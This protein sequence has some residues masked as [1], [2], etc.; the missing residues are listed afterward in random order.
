MINS[1]S[2]QLDQLFSALDEE[3]RQHLNKN[4]IIEAMKDN[5]SNEN[6]EIE[7]CGV[8]LLIKERLGEDGIKKINE[9]ISQ[10][11]KN[12]DVYTLVL[13]LYENSKKLNEPTILDYI[14]KNANWFKGKAF[15]F[16]DPSYNEST[17]SDIDECEFYQFQNR[18]FVKFDLETQKVFTIEYN[19]KEVLNVYVYM[20]EKQK[21]FNL[22]EKFIGKKSK[23]WDNINFYHLKEEFVEEDI[24]IEEGC[25]KVELSAT[26]KTTIF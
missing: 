8:Y 9:R 23:T 12:N 18:K 1:N 20:K 6:K 22:L 15:K 25:Y 14:D 17:R 13:C 2:D 4:D 26:K 19:E 10:I 16:N 7:E 11:D 5:Q 24:R 21:L 3:Q